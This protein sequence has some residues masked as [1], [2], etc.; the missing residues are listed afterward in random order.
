MFVW[1]NASSH[2]VTTLCPSTIDVYGGY[3]VVDYGSVY[4][5][6]CL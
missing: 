4:A 3:R 5:F 1:I 2:D 6:V